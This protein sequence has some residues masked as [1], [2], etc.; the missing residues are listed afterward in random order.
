MVFKQLLSTEDSTEDRYIN[1]VLVMF[2]GLPKLM[3]IPIID[4]SFDVEW[5]SKRLSS[6]QDSHDKYWL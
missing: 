5:S 4:K 6:T 2:N 1:T 3:K